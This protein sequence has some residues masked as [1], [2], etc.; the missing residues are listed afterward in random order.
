MV[1]TK[2]VN[3]VRHLSTPKCQKYLISPEGVQIMIIKFFSTDQFQSKQH[4]EAILMQT[5]IKG[6]ELCSTNDLRK[7]VVEYM[8]TNCEEFKVKST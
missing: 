4:L 2:I 1:T 7:L 8:A 6:F 5:Q 3:H